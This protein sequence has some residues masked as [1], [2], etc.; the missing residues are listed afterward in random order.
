M[1]EAGVDLVTLGVF[2][3]ALLEPR[4]GRVRLRLARRGRWTCCTR[5]ASRST[6]PPPPPRRR[7]GSRGAPGDAA[8]PPDGTALWPGSRQAWCPSSPVF[9]EHALRAG[10]RSPSATATTRRWPCG[11]STTSTAATSR[12]ATATSAPRPSATGCVARYGDLDA[13]NDAWGTA[14]WCSATSDFDEVLPPR[15]AADLRQPHPAARLPPLLL[16]RS[17]SPASSPSATC[18]AAVTRRPGHH[19]L[20]GHAHVRDWTTCLGA[21]L[22]VV[23]KTTT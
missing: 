4:A 12:A 3:W 11:T 20:H 6:S 10:R 8:G 18:C 16:R 22:D 17:C 19:Q 7:R 23:S 2:S 5:P 9:R 1:R 15:V 14:F 21:R 13:L